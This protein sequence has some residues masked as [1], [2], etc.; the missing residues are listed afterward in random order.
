VDV[1]L[2]VEAFARR[3][4]AARARRD[5]PD[6]GA[7]VEA[8]GMYG[9]ALARWGGEPLA[10]FADQP[11]ATVEAARLAQLRL[12]AL[13]ERAHLLLSLG[14]PADA[15]ADLNPVVGADPTH[16]TLAG[17]L[18]DGPVPVGAAGGRAGGVLRTRAGPRRPVTPATRLGSPQL[19]AAGL[20][21][22]ARIAAADGSPEALVEARALLAQA[23]AVREHGG[24]PRAP[25]ERAELAGLTDQLAGQV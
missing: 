7:D 10:D 5:S 17:L 12:A 9:T 4:R 8:A 3:V 21:G 20:E 25:Y 2:D 24:R 22:L 6:N 18:I 1:E 19:V 14:R 13:T 11:W 23:D 16:K 15:V